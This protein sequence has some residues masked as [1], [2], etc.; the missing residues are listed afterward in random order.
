[1]LDKCTQNR[2]IKEKEMKKLLGEH[3]KNVF[4]SRFNIFEEFARKEEIKWLLRELIS[5]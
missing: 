2:K 5:E 4:Q 1:L 3:K